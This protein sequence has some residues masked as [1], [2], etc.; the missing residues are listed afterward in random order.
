MSVRLVMVTMARRLDT[1]GQGRTVDADNGLFWEHSETR[2]FRGRARSQGRLGVYTA[3][4]RDG[5]VYCGTRFHTCLDSAR[6]D[7]AVRH[8]YT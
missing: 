6:L 5:S 2:S 3:C 7:L 8:P 4:R 1:R